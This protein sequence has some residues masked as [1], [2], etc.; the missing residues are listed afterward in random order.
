MSTTPLTIEQLE[1][2]LLALHEASLELVREMSIDTLLE[3]IAQHSHGSSKRQFCG[4]RH[5]GY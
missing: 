5:S 1:N 4:R 2:R 3:K